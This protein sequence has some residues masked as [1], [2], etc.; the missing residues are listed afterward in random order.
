MGTERK[1]SLTE[2]I[3]TCIFYSAMIL[4]F[5]AFN[6][7]DNPGGWQLQYLPNLNGDQIN[8]VI[9]LD[10]LTGF[11]ITSNNSNIAYI[12]KTT[13]S[14]NN[15]LIKKT[16]I[17]PFQRIFFCNS[18][19]GYCSSW[20]TLYKTTNGGDN[21]NPISIS[22][23][24]WITDMH[25][26]NKDTIWA[27]DNNGL[28]GGVF[29]T[30]NG[31]LKWLQ[32]Y[33]LFNQNPDKIYMVNKNLGFM[34]RGFTNSLKRTTDGGF[35]WTP[36]S[37]DTTFY[38]MYFIDSLTGWKAGLNVKKTT[39]G[40]LTWTWQTLPQLNFNDVIKKFS[41]MNN[42][43]IFGVG[44]A[45]HFLSAYRGI[46]YKTTNGGINWGYQIPDTSFGISGSFWFVNFVDKMKG[47]AFC[48]NF[49]KNIFTLTGGSDT[50]LYTNIKEQITNVVSDYILYQNFPNPFNATS[51]IKYKIEKTANVKLIVF[52]ITGKEIKTLINKKQ[53][54]GNY[55]IKFDGGNLSS[56]VYFY[57]L[58]V[59]GVRVD[60]KKMV[61]L[62]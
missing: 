20:D 4:F 37:E 60:T 23:G 8:D 7:R 11:F 54:S 16:N 51:N 15:W 41:F 19:T 10:S 34:R 21:W 48:P 47:W 28:E 44:G 2:K 61:L 56:G 43:T 49:N 35:N 52:D 31:G 24:F 5:V 14:G 32:Q 55:E 1:S 36:I 39:D 53:S 18:T 33:Y 46:V 22:A 30:T 59:D 38:D 17:Y 27:V 13:D 29:R 9:F 57:T 58:F 3:I 50:T 62:K 40:G 26:L 42:D 45:I 6:F 25:V 12:Y